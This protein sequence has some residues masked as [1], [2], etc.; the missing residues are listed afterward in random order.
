MVFRDWPD[1]IVAARLGSPLV[2]GVGKGENFIASDGFALAGHTE[3]IVYLAD[4]EV[5]IVTADSIRV[6]HRDQ[7]DVA[8]T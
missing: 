6:I 2:I 3:K 8:T 4:H 5:A 7:G 1:V